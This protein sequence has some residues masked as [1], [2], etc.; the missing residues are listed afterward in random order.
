MSL[1]LSAFPLPPAE[2][3]QQYMLRLVRQLQIMI[4]QLTSQGPVTAGADLT[5]TDMQHPISALTLINMPTSPANLPVGSVWSNNGILQMVGGAIP[6]SSSGL[7][8][9]AIWNDSGTLKVV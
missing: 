7:P 8:S 6:T 5:Q 2:Y 9:G 4:N 1:N 3:S